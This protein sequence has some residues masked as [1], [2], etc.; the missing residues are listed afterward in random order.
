MSAAT[1]AAPLRIDFVSDISCP[2]CVIGLRALEE[3]LAKLHDEVT[4]EIHFQPFELNPQMPPQGQDINE[5]LTQKYGS[6]P[7][8]LEQSREALRAR[9][10]SLGFDFRMDRRSRVYNTFDAH[11]MLHWAGLEGRQHALKHALFRAY[12][13]DGE[14]PASHDTLVRLATEVGLD[15]E[16]ARKIL[17]ADEFAAD[18]RAQER[19]YAGHGINA[20]PAVIVNDRHLI[21]GGQPVETFVRALRQIAATGASGKDAHA[22]AAG[23]HSA[24][25]RVPL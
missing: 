12:F 11:R 14:S 17:D 18:V 19:F 16:R 15:P 21:S 20:V 4:A 13:T 9:G 25:T 5:H 24:G 1:Q 7:A 23:V 6:S 2:W 22:G 3:A 10:A 8:Q